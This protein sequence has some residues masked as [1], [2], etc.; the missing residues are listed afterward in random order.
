MLPSCLN[1]S[2]LYVLIFYD[3][4][5]ASDQLF[6]VRLNLGTKDALK[7]RKFFLEMFPT[8]SFLR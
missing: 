7:S 6:I 4:K 3:W 5:S 2:E 1:A 8:P